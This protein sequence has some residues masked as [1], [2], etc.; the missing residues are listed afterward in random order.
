[1]RL[2]RSQIRAQV[3]SELAI[4]FSD[5]RIS[6]HGGLERELGRVPTF[7]QAVWRELL[8]ISPGATG[9]YAQI[10]AR[11]GSPKA[12]RAVAR[13]NGDNFRSLAI[14]CHRVIGSDGSL[15]GY[16]G[17]LAR[18]QW[19]LDHERRHASAAAGRP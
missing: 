1:V 19:L 7:Q 4:T 14:P 2:S 9:S 16:A 11:L 3:K 13:A 5:E 8:R 12:V 15:T 6:S 17:G 10:T 18:K